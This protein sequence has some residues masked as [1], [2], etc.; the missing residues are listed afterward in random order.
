MFVPG[1]I[2]RI[3]KFEEELNKALELEDL[4]E[5]KLDKFKFEKIGDRSPLL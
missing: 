4:L 5:E 1:T 3:G 2:Y